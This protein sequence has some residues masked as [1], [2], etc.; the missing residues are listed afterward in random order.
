MLL[1]LHWLKQNDQYRYSYRKNVQSVKLHVLKRKNFSFFQCTKNGPTITTMAALSHRIDFRSDRKYQSQ[2]A[3][4]F[5]LIVFHRELSKISPTACVIISKIG[6]K[7]DFTASSS[8]ALP[9][10]RFEGKNVTVRYHAFY[11]LWFVTWVKQWSTVS[12][13][14]CRNAGN[15]TFASRF[16]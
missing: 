7:Q 1:D 9:K 16:R 2:V 10:H 14:Y 5:S 4:K 6:L 8:K 3:M 12:V 13:F 15:M 11:N